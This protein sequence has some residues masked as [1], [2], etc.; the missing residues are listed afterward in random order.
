M[1]AVVMEALDK[2]VLKDVPDPVID[3][4]SALM[5]VEAVSICG[6]DVRILHRGNPRV[7]PPAIIGHE[8]AGVVVKVGKNVTRVKEGDRVA[9]GADVP[10]GQCYWCRNGMGNNCEI[11][12]AVGYQIPGVFAEYMKLT[13]LVLEEGP[14]TPFAERLSFDEASLAEPLACAINGLER[15]NMSLGKTVVIF[16]LGPIGCMM[17]G[18]ART[19]GATKIIGIE[20]SEM[21]MKIGKQYKADEYINPSGIDVVA[22]CRELTAGEGP[23]IDITACGA[24]EVHEQAV[25]MV[26]HR[27]YVNLFGGLGKDVRPMSLYSN[28][29]HYK[30]CCVTGSHGSVP[31]Q[32]ELAVS[33][34]EQGMI[35]V[36]PLITHRF[37]ISEIHKAFETMESRDG[38]KIVVHP[39]E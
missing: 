14:V 11:N 36:K 38:M 4:N 32:H 19:M 28:T 34:L 24:V 7:K 27:G 21:R 8:A 30:E 18:L 17:I 16:G 1:K 37:P 12:Y 10:C 31:R 6:S 5:R 23:D 39:Q 26:R 2:L 9:L 3:D 33:L 35:Q 15:V 29:V 20:P 25:E 13:Q 22:R